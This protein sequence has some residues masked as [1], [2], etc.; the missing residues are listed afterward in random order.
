M[1]N[2]NDGSTMLVFELEVHTILFLAF[3]QLQIIQYLFTG[4]YSEGL[5]WSYLQ[6]QDKNS[7]HI[8]Y[9]KKKTWPVGGKTAPTAF[10]KR[11]QD[12]RSATEAT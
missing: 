6:N 11:T 10:S 7:A 12:L 5:I 9:T 4:E 2:R 3:K 1:S 8:K